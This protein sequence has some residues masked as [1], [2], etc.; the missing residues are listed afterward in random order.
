MRLGYRPALDGLRALAIAPVV[1]L[2]AYGWPREGSLGVDLFFVL[3]GFL[4]TVL[5]L[6]ERMVTGSISLKRFWRRR[7]VRLGPALL[8]MLG[9]YTVASRGSHTW[10]V[11]FGATYTSNVANVVAIERI[12]WSLGHLWSLAQEE[13]FYLLWPVLLLGILRIRPRLVTRVLAALVVAVS[14]EKIA[15]LA[16][17]TA[18]QRVYFAPDTHADPIL[19]GCLF[20]SV[21]ASRGIPGAL[22]RYRRFVGPLTLLA[23]IAILVFPAKFSPF[24]ATSPLRSLYAIACGLLIFAV[25]DGGITAR[26]LSLQPLAFTG[27][28]SYSLYL[29][30]VP[31]LAALGATAY[32]G[33]T[34]RSTLAIALSAGV[35]VGSYSLVERPLRARW[36]KAR[37]PRA[38][39]DARVPAA[40][41]IAAE[42]LSA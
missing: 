37:Q 32:D 35:A 21:Y 8:V 26:L 28:I 40:T 17:G 18:W 11:V 42:G 9:I 15:L 30:H 3:S 10:A 41:G 27:R 2:H 6:E 16:A 19:I 4:I 1:G 23:I 29:W 36:G 13:Q 33:R 12:P 14:V 39:V 5:L 22:H 24:A 25:I 20:G 38:A 34:S 31:I 7:A